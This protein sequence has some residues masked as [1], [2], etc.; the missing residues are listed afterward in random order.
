[1]ADLFSRRN[2][3]LGAGGLVGAAAIGAA[4]YDTYATASYSR[5]WRMGLLYKFSE[6]STV[7]RL[8]LRATGEGE[9]ML[10]VNSAAA[11]WKGPDGEMQYNPWAFSASREQFRDYEGLEGKLVAIEYR[12]IMHRWHSWKGD[13]NYRLLGMSPVDPKLGDVE[14][15]EVKRG[16][17]RSSGRRVGRLVKVTHKGIGVKSWE[18]TVQEAGTGNNFVDMSMIDDEI[19]DA[20]VAYLRSGRLLSIGYVETLIRNPLNRD[21]NYA[22]TALK[23]VE[24]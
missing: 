8:Y 20:A 22:I 5:G 19:V 11:E 2:L 10:G 17:L 14:G 21:T 1:M 18:V 15:V 4:A 9:V 12:R 7:R 3:L 16:G 13:T 23:P 6:K 24:E